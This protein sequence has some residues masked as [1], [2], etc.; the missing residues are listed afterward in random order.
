M[1]TESNPL[2]R[3]L[4]RSLVAGSHPDSDVLTAFAEGRLLQR[5]REE[6]FAH[7]ASCADCRELLSVASEAQEKPVT[8][9]K[10]YLAP[11]PVPAPLR[12]W[13]PWVGLAAGILVV[14]SIGLFHKQR[15]DTKDHATVASENA[16]GSRPAAAHQPGALAQSSPQHGAEAQSSSA[17]VAAGPEETTA[18]GAARPHWRINDAGQV[19]GSFGDGLWKAVL[20]GEKSKMRVVSV[21]DGDVW[22][23]GENSRL[24]HSTDSGATWKLV[25]LPEKDGSEHVVI[26]IRFHSPRSGTVESADGTTWTTSDGGTS[27]R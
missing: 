2:R 23:G 26:H 19:E 15:S 5:E 17:F 21:F 3:E 4:A 13:L 27:W 7:L 20:P 8:E 12:T 22:V 24:Y 11:R 16:V 18:G 9:L 10:P 14:C 25:T 1:K 6:V